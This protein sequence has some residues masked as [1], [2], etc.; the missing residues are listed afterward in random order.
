MAN[1]Y[2]PFSQLCAVGS[3]LYA[4]TANGEVWRFIHEQGMWTLIEDHRLMASS[5][6][7]VKEKE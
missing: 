3:V 5:G 4:L 6:C 2:V 7:R 1:G